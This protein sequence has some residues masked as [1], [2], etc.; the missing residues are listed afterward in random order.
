MNG[1]KRPE[2]DPVGD[3]PPGWLRW[4]CRRGAKELDLLLN[5]YLEKR[6][7]YAGGEE[8][9][10]FERLTVWSDP[11]IMGVLLGN[12]PPPDAAT[13]SLV[14]ILRSLCRN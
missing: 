9:S 13:S 8:R 2:M 6:Y 4:R 5:A 11:D 3:R 7:P 14:E 12:G 10:A 1:G